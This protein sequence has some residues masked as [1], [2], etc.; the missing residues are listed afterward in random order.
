MV[1]PQPGWLPA[2]AANTEQIENIHDCCC[3]KTCGCSRLSSYS[4]LEGDDPIHS[5]LALRSPS[6][7]NNPL[8]SA[9]LFVVHLLHWVGYRNASRKTHT[10]LSL[11]VF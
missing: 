3:I 1:S 9:N 5:Q 4:T 7:L 11:G 8:L 2:T 10:Y 6:V